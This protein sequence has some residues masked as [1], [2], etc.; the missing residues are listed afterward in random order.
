MKTF[1]Q[2]TKDKYI[3]RV[4]AHAEADAIIKGSYWQDGKGCAVGCTIE[5]SDHD[6]YET[7]LG[8]PKEI[9]FLEDTIFENL[10]NDVAM[11]F[12]LR[13]LEAVP[14]N[15]DLSKVLAK[16]VIWQFE[17]EKHGLKNIKE[18]QDDKEVLGFCEEV[19]ALYK[20]TLTGVV[21]QGEFYDLYVKIDRAMARAGA[22]A[23]AWAWA[24]AWARAGAG[25]WARAWAGADYDK[26]YCIMADKL[27]ELI[28]ECK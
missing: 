11:K 5:G 26:Y 4:K 27:V 25:A 12:P 21:S 16:F 1:N 6:R 18:V 13:F 24:G 2:E 19:V 8:I 28:K 9:A 22:M 3:A 14:V 10:P 20:R 15:A 7:E 23:W 17:D